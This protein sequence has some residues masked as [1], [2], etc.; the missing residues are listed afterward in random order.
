MTEFAD[1]LLTRILGRKHVH[2]R[3]SPQLIRMKER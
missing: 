3:I 2:L 1:M